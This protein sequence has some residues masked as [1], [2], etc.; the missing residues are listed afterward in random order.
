MKN[1]AIWDVIPCSVVEICN[2]S[3]EPVASN[4]RF[5]GFHVLKT[6]HFQAPFNLFTNFYINVSV[7]MVP[8]LNLWTK[9]YTAC[10]KLLSSHVILYNEHMFLPITFHASTMHCRSLH[11]LL[12]ATLV[13]WHQRPANNISIFL[14]ED[15]PLCFD[16]SIK[17]F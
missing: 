14:V 9:N 8:H 11:M 5:K 6:S 1:T 13:R 12:P 2:V 17:N 16:N 3:E 15:I 4:F 10:F 7:S